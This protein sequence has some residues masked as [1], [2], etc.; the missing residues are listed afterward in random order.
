MALKN[1]TD[2]PR[3]TDTILL[4]IETTDADGC[5][6]TPYKV[7]SVTVY[8]VERDFLGTNWGE[9]AQRIEV[10]DLREELQD[11][12]EEACA[13]PSTENLLEVERLQREVESSTISVNFYYK[14]RA[15]I[16]VI[17][18]PSY[19]AWLSTDLDN[20]QFTQSE[21]EDEN[22]IEGKFEYEWNPQGSIR[23]GDY[24]LCWTWTPLPAGD[25]LSAHLPFKVLGDPK[26][27]TSIPTHVTAD[28]KYETLLE[29][30]LPEMYKQFV[31]D[32]DL[33]PQTTL[34]L[35]QS[36]AKGFTVLENFANQIIDLFDANA[37]HESLLMY[38]SNLFNIKLKSSDPTLWRRQIKEAIPLFKKKGTLEALQSAFAQSGM[39]LNSF[40][41]YWQIVSQYTWQESFLVTDSDI[42]AL[43][44]NDI[45][46]P[47]DEDNFGLWVRQ[48]GSD[49]YTSFPNT[50]VSFEID[51]DCATPVIMTW[52]GDT[53]LEEGD[54]VRV[55]YQFKDIPGPTEQQYED[56]IQDLP[57][58][59]QRDETDQNYPPKNWN[60][61]II[62]EADP[63]FATLVPVGHP[64]ADPIIFGHVRTEF[65]YS[66]NIYNMEEYN[67][68]T[69]PSTDSCNIDKAFV[70]PC[71][72]C[73]GSAY[74]VDIGVE[75]LSNDRMLEAQ[76]ILKEYMPFHAVLH[77]ISFTGEFNEFS[78][79]P[80]EQFDFLV[81]VDRLDNNLS[82]QANATFDRS[83]P[84]GLD[85]AIIDREDLADRMTVLSDE[86]GTAYNDHVAL[87]AP[88]VILA[89]LGILKNSHILEVLSPSV[90]AGTYTLT[91]FQGHTAEVVSSVIEPV[92]ESQ[93]TFDLSN[94]TYTNATTSITQDDLFMF[95]DE[96]VLF[97]DLG[98]KTLWD[99]DNTPDY[100][101]GA[102]KVKILAYSPTPYEIEDIVNGALILVDDGTLPVGGASGVT[103]VLL[104]DD[105]DE[106]TD[107]T[108]GVIEVERR[109]FVTFNDPYILNIHDFVR[110]G[111][112]LFYDNE[113]YEVVEFNGLDF[114]IRGWIDGDLAGANVQIRRRLADNK[115]GYFGY[116]GLHLTTS[117]DH[118]AEFNVM[119]GENPPGVIIENNAFKE[120][121][122]F[123][124][125]DD[126]FKVVSWDGDHVELAGREQTWETLG[127][128]GTA[129]TYNL[130]QFSKGEVTVQ[131]ITFSEI[132][133]DGHD[134]IVMTM[135]GDAALTAL[136]A[137]GAGTEENSYQEEGV[138]FLIQTRDGDTEEGEL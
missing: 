22:P 125:G 18:T 115:V 67:G 9:Y 129:V 27:V 20:V 3:T 24:F 2:S 28:D 96:G 116:R 62:E 80:V 30:Y 42:F 64:F 4:T 98:V 86:A 138:S 123:Q 119:N 85:D 99:V 54:I 94:I 113:E 90:N 59:D 73:L 33:T 82:G 61:R 127:A 16:E 53:E 56:Y 58:L 46:L 29:L 87:V 66:E 84:G 72:A 89:D 95:S 103:Y 25:R 124:I 131:F 21:D 114:W 63:M 35:N 17:G 57:L 44:K 77:S 52:I 40:T 88:D 39:V 11:A 41:Q 101:G 79:P 8:Y 106:I 120:N 34:N 15:A 50:D 31:S 49:I 43:T 112:L 91:D 47:I 69:R 117:S 65:A 107:S 14:D 136:A 133:R 32:D 1:F 132:D 26:A 68:S 38:L 5:L 37:L 121:F 92:N 105:D 70:D 108:D 36:V 93:F 122:L 97:E 130:I 104:N 76:E 126:F 71:G 83:M 128:G 100:T 74:S 110:L 118:E 137:G 10:D 134:V 23:E 78:Q 13:D 48:V 12:I 55:L 75:E 19:P 7:D 111:D 109:A 51:E 102:W 60:V 135:D 81:T 45:V 6:E